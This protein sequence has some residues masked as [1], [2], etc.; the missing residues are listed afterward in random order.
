[1]TR[2]FLFTH[3]RAVR[4]LRSIEFYFPKKADYYL[5]RSAL[6]SLVRA[7]NRRKVEDYLLLAKRYSPRSLKE[8]AKQ[9]YVPLVL[10]ALSQLSDAH[11]I[12]DNLLNKI[13]YPS[14]VL[15]PLA[16]TEFSKNVRNRNLLPPRRSASVVTMFWFAG[17]ITGSSGQNR[18]HKVPQG[19]FAARGARRTRRCT[20]GDKRP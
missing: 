6:V 10:S 9:L 20:F 5:M 7:A 12:N 3:P 13:N 14:K 17:T 15:G 18:E 19:T 4:E 8:T 16:E 2:P 1:M 11:I